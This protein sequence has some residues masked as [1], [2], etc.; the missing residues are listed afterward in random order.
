MRSLLPP[1]I[2]TSFSSP[3]SSGWAST[4]PRTPA[5]SCRISSFPEQTCSPVTFCIGSRETFCASCIWDPDRTS[6][7]SWECSPETEEKMAIRQPR[8]SFSVKD[9]THVTNS[10]DRKNLD[11]KFMTV[12]VSRLFSDE[13][14]NWVF[15]SIC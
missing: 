2:S 14:E 1:R 4:V 6:D 12:G 13:G 11:W 9:R 10:V 3:S 7:G 15:S 8:G 5:V